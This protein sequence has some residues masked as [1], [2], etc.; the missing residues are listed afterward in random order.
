[1]DVGVHSCGEGKGAVPGV[2]VGDASWIRVHSLV[3]LVLPVAVHGGG[4]LNSSYG[5][6]ICAVGGGGNQKCSVRL[7]L[8][9]SDLEQSFE[10]LLLQERDLGDS[11]LRGIWSL[12]WGGWL[13]KGAV[14]DC[15]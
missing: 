7:W 9:S 6:G 3:V 10:V 5:G 4:V 13:R 11:S 12:C 8:R 2:P 15:A 1:M 14:G